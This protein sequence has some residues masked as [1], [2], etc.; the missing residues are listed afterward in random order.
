[1]NPPVVKGI[2]CGWPYDIG[3]ANVLALE[4]AEH[5]VT[6][7]CIVPAAPTRLAEG[8]DTDAFAP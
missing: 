2:D 3:L 8:R 1:L 6:A 5:G 4:G 7:N